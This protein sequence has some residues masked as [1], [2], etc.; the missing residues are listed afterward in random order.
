[1]KRLINYLFLL[2][3]VAIISL[4]TACDRLE[5]P[6]SPD[7]NPINGQ[8]MMKV[9]GTN[10]VSVTGDTIY[11]ERNVVVH[12]VAQSNGPEITNWSWNIYGHNYTGQAIKYTFTAVPV[13][14]TTVTLTGT[15]SNQTYTVTKVIKIMASIDGLKDVQS[16]SSTPAGNNKFNIILAFKKAG[17][18][19]ATGSSY[20]YIGDVTNP[21]WSNPVS[22]LTAD[23]NYN[24]VNNSLVTPDGTIGKYIAV[25]LTLSPR[26]YQIGVGKI[27][28]GQQ[29]WGTFNDSTIV[30]FRV[31]SDGSVTLSNTTVATL[32]GVVG[33]EGTNAMVRFDFLADRLLIYLNNQAIFS[34]LNPFLSFQ[35]STGVWLAPINQASVSSYPNWGVIQMNYSSLPQNGLLVFNYG[36]QINSP[37]SYQANRSLSGYWD[38][39]SQ[40]LKAIISNVFLSKVLNNNPGWIAKPVQ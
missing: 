4:L 32:P 26:D 17:M 14:Y 11:V 6:T 36:P 16:I 19:Y 39:S 10:G 23:T 2:T 22:V 37:T 18:D 31:N 34:S 21:A 15:A 30:R 38:S 40:T 27:V 35:D 24:I 5:A 28:N 8:I 1:M 12:F 25:R 20:F 29:M 9:S 33:D 13:A 7:Q 3:L